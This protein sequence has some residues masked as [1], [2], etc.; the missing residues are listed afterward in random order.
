MQRHRMEFTIRISNPRMLPTQ[1][2]SQNKSKSTLFTVREQRSC[3]STIKRYWGQHRP[4]VFH[5]VAILD[6][7]FHLLLNSRPAGELPITGFSSCF[8][9]CLFHFRTPTGRWK[10]GRLKLLRQICMQLEKGCILDFF[11]LL[12][13]S[14]R[15]SSYPILLLVSFLF[16]SL[17]STKLCC[18]SSAL[19]PN[20]VCTEVYLPPFRSKIRSPRFHLATI[21]NSK[22][23]LHQFSI[24]K[25]N[26]N[27]RI[28]VLFPLYSFSFNF[29]PG[30]FIPR[31]VIC[32][33]ERHQH[34][35]GA[36]I[37]MF[38]YLI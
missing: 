5:I 38:S 30:S 35:P 16:Y 3:Y 15:S 23:R 17:F 32:L 27:S 9:S 2:R 25:M 28:F 7:H 29:W 4:L 24:A 31:H 11:F 10:V 34:S 26:K 18:F 13:T 19:T 37:L 14:G 22:W 6:Q 21:S 20:N 12:R 36:G 33:L 1:L 8:G